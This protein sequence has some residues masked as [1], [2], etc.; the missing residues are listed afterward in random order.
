MR[1]RA[2]DA[3]GAH[4][5]A[6]HKSMLFLSYLGVPG[7]SFWSSVR[8]S[9]THVDVLAALF[10]AQAAQIRVGVLFS[11]CTKKDRVIFMRRLRTYD[12]TWNS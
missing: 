9:R 4:F 5:I 10:H 12:A 6:L 3:F 1:E 11:S 8:M 7:G 2:A